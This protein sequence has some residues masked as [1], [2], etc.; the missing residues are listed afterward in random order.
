MSLLTESENPRPKD[1]RIETAANDADVVI[2]LE[3]VSVVY[4]APRERIKTFKEYVIRKVKRQVEHQQFNA[5]RDASL[6][7]RRG[8]VFGL[9]G[10]NGA[11][12]STMLKLVSRVMKPTRG[13]VW[14]KGKIAP[15]LELGAG[16]HPELSGRENIFLNGTLLGY[17][18]AE[19]AKLFDSIVEFA[20][21]EDFIDAPLRTYS[22]GMAGRL[23]FAVAT[24]TRPDILIVDEVLSVG[25]EQ[26]QEKCAERITEFRRQGTTILLVT[27][28][29][30]LV[31]R[32]CDRAA[33]LD[34]GQIC[35]VGQPAEIV[36]QYH[37][38]YH[39]A[40]PV[41]EPEPVE[42]SE[43]VPEEPKVP[44]IIVTEQLE[45]AE[46]LAGE[47][48]VSDEVRAL[49]QRA[50]QKAWF[51]PFALP[52]G[53]RVEC[54]LPPHV[55][56]IHANRLAM[57]ESALKTTFGSDWSQLDCLDVGSNQGF[58]SVKLA[59]RGC[60]NVVGLEAR[61]QNIED[62]ELIR[63]MYDLNNLSFRNGD[64]TKLNPADWPQF[65]VTIMLSVLFWL[66]NPIGVLRTLKALTRHLLILETPVAPEIFGE[67]DWGS[68]DVRK[69]LQGSFALL[70]L[71]EES[72]MHVGSLTELSFCPGRESLIWLLRKLG[73]SS[74]EIVAPLP[75]AYE[76]LVS[77]SR[78]MV[79]AR[80]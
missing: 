39:L 32:I 25:D 18:R 37:D 2:R 38:R 72:K 9:I 53:R 50:L 46:P 65:D 34:H 4:R 26:F 58:F 59:Q 35:S 31:Q 55:A 20:E 6:E 51:Y 33:W 67:M 62:A 40:S 15:L 5:L 52:S 7:L 71:T 42:G 13:R 60:R 1:K 44:K 75:E 47:S 29:S 23:G 66:E 11:G 36:R 19:M 45:E 56:V 64:V 63:K 16:F 28:S 61:P 24:A 43:P 77:G 80:V 70:D 21:I 49:E 12:K 14:V 57:V 3:N 68:R 74:V 27:H 76:Q 79:V 48:A 73:F 17:S 69:Q 8:E 10:H 22:T 41:S 78:V 54:Y 30:E